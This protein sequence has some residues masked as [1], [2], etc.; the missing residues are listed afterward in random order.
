MKRLLPAMLGLS[1]LIAATGAAHAAAV[2]GHTYTVSADT[3]PLSFTVP[4]Y[5]STH[6]S[7]DP[8]LLGQDRVSINTVAFNPALGSIIGSVANLSFGGDTFKVVYSVEGFGNEMVF[9][10]T[11]SARISALLNGS[12]LGTPETFDVNLSGSCGGPDQEDVDRLCSAKALRTAFSGADSIV[13]P[14]GT[15]AHDVSFVYSVLQSDEHCVENYYTGGVITLT[16]ACTQ[17]GTGIVDTSDLFDPTWSAHVTM[18]YDYVPE[19]AS[20]ALLGFGAACVVGARRR[21]A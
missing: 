11:V 1:L 3:G 15:N 10:D 18:T 6:F 8:V 13:L 21:R 2:V 20:I 12:P 9:S 7:T 16:S 17:G 5:M 14:A 19:P 4:E